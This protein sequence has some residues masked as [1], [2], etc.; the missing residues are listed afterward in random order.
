M[1]VVWTY[2][3]KLMHHLFHCQTDIL[4]QEVLIWVHSVWIVSAKQ[5]LRTSLQIYYVSLSFCN[6][7]IFKI[8]EF[9]Y[10]VLFIDKFISG[11]L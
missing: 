3:T 5:F 8:Q 9:I 2:L 4:M 10:K 6:G 11:K 1:A 7:D